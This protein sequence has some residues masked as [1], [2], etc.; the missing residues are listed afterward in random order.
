MNHKVTFKYLIRFKQN[1]KDPECSFGN[2]PFKIVSAYIQFTSK[3]WLKQ[4]GPLGKM[5]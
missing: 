4:S 5:R 2:K 1:S 3:T